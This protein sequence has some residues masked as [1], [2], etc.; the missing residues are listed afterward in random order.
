MVLP[1]P[2]VP[3]LYPNNSN[4]EDGPWH[5]AK[6]EIA[7]QLRDLT[8]LWRVAVPGRRKGHEAGIYKW[9]DPRVTPEL[10]GVTGDKRP[11]MFSEVLAINVT[12]DGPD[13]RPPKIQA[14]REEWHP[15][16]ELEFYVDFETVSDL[17]DD[18]SKLPEKGGQPLIF[19]IGCGHIEAEEWRFEPFV[20]DAISESEEARI[21][22]EWLAHMAREKARLA[23]GIAAPRIIH[24]SPA[25]VSNFETAY[26]SA[27]ERHNRPDWPS[28][29]WFDFLRR[30][31][32]EEPVVVRGSM[33]FGLKSVAKAMHSHGL[34]DTL[35]GDGPADGLGAMVGAWRCAQEAARLA[36]PMRQIDLMQ[37]IISYNEVDCKVMMEMLRYLRLHH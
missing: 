23:P 28:L 15:T 21:I 6:K 2:S 32:H 27:R 9:T 34:I 22:Q 20:V 19:M 18:F 24:W 30:V 12:D 16:P 10:V 3:E 17:A 4:D 13:V 37:E 31:M 35:W 14:A 26:N 25:E 29:A 8:M 33:A 1:E 7:E 36:V 11:A 5:Y